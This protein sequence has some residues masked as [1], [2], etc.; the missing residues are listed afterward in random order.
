[1]I[2]IWEDKWLPAPTTYKICSPQV[3]IG[4]FPMVSSLIN[5]DTRQWMVGKITWYF[6]P[7]EV[8]VILNIPL[9]YTLSKYKIIWVDNKRGMFSIKSA[10][11][12]ALPLV[13]KTEARE[14]SF[15]DYSTPLWKKLWKLKLP[16]KIKKFRLESLHGGAAN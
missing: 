10:Y 15:G 11:Y 4:D 12:V 2:H 8:E 16:T 13:E 14:S 1:M 9:S 5:K 6:L 3:D 7:F